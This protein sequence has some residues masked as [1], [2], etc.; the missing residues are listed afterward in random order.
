[1]REIRILFMGTPDFAVES[2]AQIIAAGFT[3]VGV[4]TAPDRPA[5]RGRKLQQSAVKKYALTQNLKILQP[6]NLKSDSF[7][8]ELQALNPTLQVVVAFRML[9]EKV[10]R[11][12]KY[13]TFNLHASLLPEYRG[14]APINWA[15]INGEKISGVTTF[16]I[17]EKIDT[18]AIINSK[19]IEIA[20]SETVGTVHD[21]LMKIGGELIVSTIKQIESG[22][23]KTTAQNK[24]LE[25]KPAPKLSKENTKIDWSKPILN[26]YNLIRGLNPYPAA[27]CILENNEKSLKVKIFDCEMALAETNETPGTVSIED[28]TLKIS[29]IDGYL[30]IKEIQLPGKRKMKVK[31]LL[32]GLTLSEDAKMR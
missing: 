17:D 21:R 27:W 15:V 1:M 25:E 30:F 5:G 32:N 29:A 3:V 18:G 20:P 7:Q 9:P 31:D 26:I 16:F 28:K 24:E 13:G 14:A 12:P 2:L 10:W 6:T 4:V 23:V 8:E 22:E 11:F 19:K